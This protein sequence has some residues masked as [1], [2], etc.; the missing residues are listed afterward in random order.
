[1]HK[2]FQIFV[3]FFQVKQRETGFLMALTRPANLRCL[4]FEAEGDD[5]PREIITQDLCKLFHW[6]SKIATS[7]EILNK[8]LFF[9]FTISIS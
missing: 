1:M 9:S 5:C 8:F 2:S 3:H 4:L 6:D 7:A